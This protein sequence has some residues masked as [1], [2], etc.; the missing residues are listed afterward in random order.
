MADSR[1]EAQGQSGASFSLLR[2]MRTSILISAG[3]P[4]LIYFLVRPHM[5]LLPTLA[6][7][8][9]PPLAYTLV[10][11]GHR[12]SIDLVSAIWLFS[13]G[14]SMLL[15]ILVHDPHLLLIKDSFVTTTFGLV[16]LI[17]LAT[18]RPMSYWLYRWAFVRTPERV[19]YLNTTWQVPY[20]RFVRRLVTGVWGAAFLAEGLVDGFLAYHLPTTQFVAIHPF[21]YWATFVVA[22]GW[23]ILYAKQAE[24]RIAALREARAS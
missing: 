9:V 15:A 13:V 20:T 11:W 19:A 14:V 6:L 5:A 23:G 18:P 7:M 4:L 17:S 12:H 2:D 21:L 1:I 24:P 3:L 10:G 8:A 22:F 16:C